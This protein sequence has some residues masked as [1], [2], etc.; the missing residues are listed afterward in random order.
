M[1]NNN[2]MKRVGK[3]RHD[4]TCVLFSDNAPFDGKF[5]RPRVIDIIKLAEHIEFAWPTNK[6]GL[7]I[8]GAVGIERLYDTWLEWEKMI[9]ECVQ[10]REK[11]HGHSILQ[12]TRDFNIDEAFDEIEKTKP[13]RKRVPGKKYRGM[14]RDVSLLKKAFIEC[15]LEDGETEK[16]ANKLWLLL[17]QKKH[18]IRK[19]YLDRVAVKYL[20]LLSVKTG[21]AAKK[22]RANAKP[23]KIGNLADYAHLG[24]P[25]EV[26]EFADIQAAGNKS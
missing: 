19:G 7:R 20:K 5:P 6:A 15:E 24:S 18:G 25:A 9:E 13:V 26:A 4:E 16:M 22:G 11:A 12:M 1:N 17:E 10:K 2:E 3:M 14:K 21:S 8:Y 23:A